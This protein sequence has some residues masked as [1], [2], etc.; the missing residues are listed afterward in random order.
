MASAQSSV[1]AGE[2]VSMDY[3]SSR[4]S[5]RQKINPDCSRCGQNFP[6]LEVE[7]CKH[8]FCGECIPALV[9]EAIGKKSLE[10]P[11]CKMD[12]PDALPVL[13]ATAI[14]GGYLLDNFD[15]N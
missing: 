6:T 5:S 2:S 15:Q 7:P 12:S 8:R 10:C 14:L 3:R 9:H 13:I 11:E 1:S 4:K